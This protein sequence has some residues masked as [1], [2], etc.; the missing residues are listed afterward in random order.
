MTN[1]THLKFNS[2]YFY[3]LAKTETKESAQKKNQT[4]EKAEDVAFKIQ[5]VISPLPIKRGIPQQVIKTG[6][7]YKAKRR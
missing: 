3:A 2:R 1:T 6:R 5:A 4:Q 7:D